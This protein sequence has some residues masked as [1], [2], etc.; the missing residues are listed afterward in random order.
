MVLARALESALMAQVLESDMS[1][2]EL[3]L[4]WL[5]VLAQAMTQHIG[6]GPGLGKATSLA[7][8]WHM[9]RSRSHRRP[10]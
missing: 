3:D 4:V 1:A 7:R 8:C 5:A 9:V 6:K 2:L 10:G